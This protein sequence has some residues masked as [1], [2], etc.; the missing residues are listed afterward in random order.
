MRRR[1]KSQ[2]CMSFAWCHR[3]LS[4]TKTINLPGVLKRNTYSRNDWKVSALNVFSN[5]VTSLP[6]RT[7]TAPNTPCFLR[8]GAWSSTGSLISG[9]I[10]ILCREPCCWK[11]H[12]SSN[13][14]SMFSL[15]HNSLS[16]FICPLHLRIGFGYDRTG[17]SPSESKFIETSLTLTNTELDTVSRE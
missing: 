8:V 14:R 15:R 17:F 13:Q 11:W 16:F 9:G 12:S 2:G 10:H 7:C 5:W 3:A 4:R 1:M 6:W